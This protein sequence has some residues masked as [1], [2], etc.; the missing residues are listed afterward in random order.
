MTSPE[1]G[2]EDLLSRMD[3]LRATMYVLHGTACARYFVGPIQTYFQVAST[4]LLRETCTDVPFNR[5]EWSIV[6][7]SFLDTEACPSLSLTDN[8]F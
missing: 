2:S 6:V 3:M 4:E 5:L 7:K 1:G 8:R